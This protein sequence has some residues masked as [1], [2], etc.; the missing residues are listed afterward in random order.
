M[1]RQV[2]MKNACYCHAEDLRLEAS[3]FEHALQEVHPAFG[4][5]E[6]ELALCCRG[7]IIDY[8]PDFSRIQETLMELVLQVK[9]S[10]RTPLLSVLL[11]G[12]PGCGKTAL[13]ASIGAASGFPFVKVISADT[14]IG[15]GEVSKCGAVADVF[16]DAY[17]SPLS[18]III[19]DL[20]RLI[21][22]VSI[23][24][25]FSNQVLQALLVLTKKN[26]PKAD[27]K[28]LIIGTTSVPHLLDDLELTKVFNVSLPVPML[29]SDHVK[30]VIDSMMSGKQQVPNAD[31]VKAM[32]DACTKPIGIKKLMLVLEMAAAQEGALD[33][34]RFM[35]C[36]QNVGF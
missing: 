11:S 19:D 4:V 22:F 28:L 31:E 9:T 27:R 17:K 23:G 36:L 12:P 21:E 3:D 6:D 7:G 26:P 34:N 33:V 13:A 29:E 24:P 10:D 32:A 1:N 25:R 30:A 2:D 35:E 15:M 5:Q 14:L 16:Q 8:S 20:E 18:M